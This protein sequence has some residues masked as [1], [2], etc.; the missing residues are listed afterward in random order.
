M[1]RRTYDNNYERREGKLRTEMK[2]DKHESVKILIFTFSIKTVNL[3]QTN[4]DDDPDI[5]CKLNF[6]KSSHLTNGKKLLNFGFVQPQK[7][8]S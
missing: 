1:S 8:P 6:I 4:R 2:V 5:K 3:M 7:S